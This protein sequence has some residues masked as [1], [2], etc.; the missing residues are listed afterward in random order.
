MGKLIDAD[1]LI[2]SLTNDNFLD[3]AAVDKIAGVIETLPNRAADGRKKG[4]WLKGSS[5]TVLMKNSIDSV[6]CPL[7]RAHV[8]EREGENWK[9]C[10]GCGAEMQKA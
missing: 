3:K 10:P 5:F 2:L 8:N 7:C 9:Y 1:D 6:R 4:T